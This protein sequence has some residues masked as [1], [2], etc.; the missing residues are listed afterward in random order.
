MELLSIL[1]CVKSNTVGTSS[2]IFVIVICLGICRNYLRCEL[3]AVRMCRAYLPWVCFVYVCKQTFF[4][5]RKSFFFVNKSFLIESKP[6]LYMSK[7]FFI[8]E[9][10]FNSVSFCYYLGSY[11]VYTVYT[12]LHICRLESKK[13]LYK[14]PVKFLDF[15]QS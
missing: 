6:F 8:Y 1:R 9:N 14:N 5:V 10:S 3:F 7:T 12:V 13:I 2:H 11:T 4:C 15:A